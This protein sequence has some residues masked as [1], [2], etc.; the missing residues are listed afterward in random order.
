MR[1]RRAVWRTSVV[2]AANR[3]SRAPGSTTRRP[4][5]SVNAERS[6]WKRKVTRAAAPGVS[7]TRRDPALGAGRRLRAETR[8]DGAVPKG[9]VSRPRPRAISSSQS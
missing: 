9:R 1:V 6:G 5:R 8:V 2:E 4:E 3:S 7:S